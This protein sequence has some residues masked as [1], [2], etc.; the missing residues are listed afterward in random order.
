MQIVQKFAYDKIYVKE[1]HAKTIQKS[2]IDVP[3]TGVVLTQYF[4]VKVT[5]K[6]NIS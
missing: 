4:V 6:T 2:V 1:R 3:I 5:R